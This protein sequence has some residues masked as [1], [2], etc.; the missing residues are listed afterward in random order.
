[1][2]K[3]HSKNIHVWDVGPTMSYYMSFTVFWHYTL[4]SDPG[5]WEVL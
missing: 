3:K 1:M 4:C 5:A 2:P